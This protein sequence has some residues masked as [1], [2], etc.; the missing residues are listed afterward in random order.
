MASRRRA[1]SPIARS[2]PPI[3][4]HLFPAWDEFAVF[5]CYTVVLLA[6]GAWSL[7][8]AMPDPGAPGQPGYPG[9]CNVSTP[10]CAVIRGLLRA[11]TVAARRRFPVGAPCGILPAGSPASGPA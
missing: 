1:L 2:A 10:G 8:A 11:G 7:S 3:S 5:S 4:G 9:P 6:L